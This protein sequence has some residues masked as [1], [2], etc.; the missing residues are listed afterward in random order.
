[1]PAIQARRAVGAIF[2][3]LG[4]F[5]GAWASRIPDIKTMLGVNEAGFGLVLLVM[6]C[7]AFVSFPFAGRWVDNHGASRV[8]KLM[9]PALLVMFVLLSF[10]AT[11]PLM[12]PI[13][14]LTGFCIGGLDVAMNGWGADVEKAL[15]RPV[16]SSYH[17]LYSLGA[18]TGAAA[19]AGA[20]WLGLP[21]VVHFGL[22]GLAMALLLAPALRVPWTSASK[23]RAAEK[24]PFLAIPKGTLFAV[25]LMALAAAL[26]EGAIT[27]WAALYQIKELGYSD[28]LAAI[29]FAVF[30]IAMVIMRFAGDRIVARHGA[31]TVARVSGVGAVA[32]TAL[33]VWAPGIWGVWIGCAIMG[34]GF[35]AIFPLAMSRAAADPDMSPGAAIAS[36]AT[37][38]YGAFLLGPPLLGFVG[39]VLSLRMSFAVVMVLSLAIPFFASALNVRERAN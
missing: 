22:W 2:F 30:S 15:A 34:L 23:P 29:G 9:A 16:M 25:G 8:T 24:P 35:A 10:G 28:T 18:A 5:L 31:A 39:Q 6:A 1:M 26:A 33:L 20:L 4:A 3:V 19:G 38:G 7:G 27:D 14:F 37:L 17:G 12:I 36:V 13:A 32:G 11:V 21:V